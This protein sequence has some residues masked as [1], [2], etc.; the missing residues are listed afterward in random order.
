MYVEELKPNNKNIQI[1]TDAGWSKFDAV[2]VKGTKPVVM[3]KLQYTSIILTP[4]HIVFDYLKRPRPAAS[5]KPQMKISTV[6]GIQKVVS[7]TTKLSDEVYDLIN[8][9]KNNRFYANNIL[10]SN[11]E[12]L[13]FD[14]TLISATTLIDLEG[15]EPV[16]RQ[17]QIRWYHKPEAGRTYIVALDPSL[18]TGGDPAAVQVLEMPQCRQIAEWQ[19]NKTPVPGQ[20]NIIKEICNYIFEC[21]KRENDIYYSVENNTL[22]EAALIC[23]NE[24]GEE[25]IRGIFLSEPAKMGSGRRYRKG[26]TTTN[27]SKLAACAKLKTM[28]ESKKMTLSSK[29]LVSELKNFVASANNSF[30]AKIGETD[31]LVTSLLLALRMMQVLQSFDP[32]IDNH[33]RDSFEDLLAPMPFI[34][35]S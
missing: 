6:N 7:V 1:L 32:E 30:A 5:L 4:D 22:G 25:N 28:I 26:F 27:K 34:M 33:M 20:I 31:D 14:E 17:G 13:I 29:N 10:V 35:V 9:E 8:V 3:V 2:A 19:H 11:C 21:T 24:L 16:E 12:F 23:I 18:G 15:R